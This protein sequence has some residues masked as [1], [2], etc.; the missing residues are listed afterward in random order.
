VW[1][2]GGTHSQCPLALRRSWGV[3]GDEGGQRRSGWA[4]G[5]GAEVQLWRTSAGVQR[6]GLAPGGQLP[7][8]APGGQLPGLAPGGQLPGLAPGGQLPGLAPGG[9]LPKRFGQ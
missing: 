9:Q 6:L 3:V 4:A 2:A 7:G 8:L 5:L 1:G